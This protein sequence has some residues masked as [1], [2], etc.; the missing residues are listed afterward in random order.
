MKAT[1]IFGIYEGY[2][3]NNN[4][5]IILKEIN[6]DL[7]KLINKNE[8]ET[9]IFIS[10]FVSQGHT[11]YKSEWG[12]P[13]GGETTLK[14]ESSMNPEFVED[15][16]KWRESVTNLAYKIKKHFKQ[17]TLTCEFSITNLL[18]LKGEK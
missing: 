10:G 2:S 3:H 6:E 9:G 1:I 16:V 7:I 8:E 17:S 18:Y 14:F 4:K 5:S 13:E 15:I 11:L 12:C